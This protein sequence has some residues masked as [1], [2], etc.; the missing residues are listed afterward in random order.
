[1]ATEINIDTDREVKINAMQRLQ[2]FVGRWNTTGRTSEGH[3][4]QATDVYEWLPGEFFII[5]KWKS[6][7][8][9]EAVAGIEIIGYDTEANAYFTQSYDS[10]GNTAKY[11]AYFSGN[12]WSID[13]QS[14][15]FRGGFNDDGKVLSGDWEMLKDGSWIHWM[16]IELTKVD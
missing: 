10:H 13:G 1:M 8:G 11:Q 6:R 15:R 5:H 4:L 12:V 7:L 16:E 9:E 3:K 14:E 2:Q